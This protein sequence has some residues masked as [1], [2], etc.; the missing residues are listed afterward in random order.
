MTTKDERG[1]HNCAAPV[2]SACVGHSEN[3]CP[4]LVN[5]KPIP[6]KVKSRAELE[7]E[8]TR[9]RKA[10]EVLRGDAIFAGLYY[11][12]MEPDKAERA[13]MCRRINKAVEDWDRAVAPIQV[14]PPSTDKTSEE[15]S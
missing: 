9:L 11:W 15:K 14:S 10:G 2:E 5:W 7:Q 12:A 1:C 13:K 3:G 4:G 6:P 8:I